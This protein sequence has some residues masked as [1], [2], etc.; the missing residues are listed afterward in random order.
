MNDIE[1]IGSGVIVGGLVFFIIGIFSFSSEFRV[2]ANLLFL[3]GLN[4][5]MG[6]K[7]FFSF[8]IK[9][10]KLKGTITFIVGI[11]LTFMKHALFGIISEIVG[12]YWL[13]G[14]FLSMILGVIGK[15]PIIGALIPSGIK[16]KSENLD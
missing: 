3:I 5:L 6:P 1:F 9:K 12:A 8:L 11:V 10:D 14:G 7:P 16:G 13:F 2:T 15:I 4:M